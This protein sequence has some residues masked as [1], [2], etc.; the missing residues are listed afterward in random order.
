MKNG[1]SITAEKWNKATLT[2]GEMIAFLSQLP[3]DTPVTAFDQDRHDYANVRE[4]DVQGIAEEFPI[5]NVIV[6]NDFDT[7]QW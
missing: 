3:P 5:V 2:A 4:M 6:F 7:R 1:D